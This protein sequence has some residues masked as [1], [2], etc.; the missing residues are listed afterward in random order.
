MDVR[1]R[2]LEVYRRPEA[3]QYASE[4]HL[5]APATIAPEA[6]PDAPVDLEKLFS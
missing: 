1:E 6:F 3:D 4:E 2:R 5:K